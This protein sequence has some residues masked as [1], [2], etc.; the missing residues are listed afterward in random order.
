M[1]GITRPLGENLFAAAQVTNIPVRNML[2][3]LAIP[4]LT[5][6]T[7]LMIITYVPQ[8]SLIFVGRDAWDVMQ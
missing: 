3:T 5:M 2:N 7:A 8:V 4:V 6:I 1:S